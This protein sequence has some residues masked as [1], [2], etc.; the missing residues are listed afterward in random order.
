MTPEI[1]W[2]RYAAI[3]SADEEKRKLELDSC[4]VNNATYCDP[5]G[6]IKGRSTLSDYMGNFQ[7]NARGCMFQI[8]SVIAHHD[9]SLA[10]W[11][12]NDEDGQIVQ[13]GSSFGQLS[14]DGRLL[15]IS[16]FF[17]PAQEDES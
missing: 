9:R 12:M 15:N 2:N 13:N 14:D 10:H 4:L 5:N 11:T 8:R 6:L 16:G 17:Y 7:K 3:W 1:L